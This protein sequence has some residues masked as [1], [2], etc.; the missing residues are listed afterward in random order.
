MNLVVQSWGLW[1]SSASAL[2]YPELYVTSTIIE[3][4]SFS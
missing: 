4:D 1:N 3:I 2:L